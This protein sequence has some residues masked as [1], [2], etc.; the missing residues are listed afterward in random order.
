[1]NITENDT[2]ESVHSH[3]YPVEP[4]RIDENGKASDM[5]YESIM[6]TDRCNPVNTDEEL[7]MAHDTH[8]PH[9]PVVNPATLT[10]SVP[11]TYNSTIVPAYFPGQNPYESR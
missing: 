8:N 5:S 3:G 11:G 6:S 1:M 9:L 2:A 4:I 10:G 7:Q